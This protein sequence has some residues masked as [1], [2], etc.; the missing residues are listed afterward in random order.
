MLLVH[1]NTLQ[2]TATHC[3]T[4]QDTA[5]HCNTMQ[6]NATHC[7]TLQHT[8]THC[9]TLQHTATHCNTLQHT[10]TH[11]NTL[12]H[13][14]STA[15][16]CNTMQQLWLICVI[17][18]TNHDIPQTEEIGLKLITTVKFY[19]RG[20]PYIS[21]TFWRESPNFH[22]SFRMCKRSPRDSK[23][24]TIKSLDL[25]IKYL[26]SL[27]SSVSSLTRRIDTCVVKYSLLH[28]EFQSNSL[29]NL[30]RTGLYSIGLSTISRLLKII[31]LFFKRALYKRRHFAKETY[32]LIHRA[33]LQKRPIILRSL[34]I[35]ATPYVCH[36][37]Q[38]I[39]FGVSFNLSIQSQSNWSF[40]N[41][42]WQKRSRER[43][44]R[45]VE[46]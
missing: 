6:H 1:C 46:A 26:W 40:F 28:L 14:A 43:G 30:N 25:E 16:H 24:L 32:C 5:T 22:T 37:V 44:K 38:P 41:G 29:S 21:N 23:D 8:A 17:R 9:N 10:S 33:L 2:H 42:T 34:L 12:Q 20:S 36:Q 15:T 11:C 39:V 35:V 13:T 3:N 4:L 7:N 18:D 27:I 45:D 31:G 19:S